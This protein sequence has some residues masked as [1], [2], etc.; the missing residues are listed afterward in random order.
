VAR[1]ADGITTLE[2]LDGGT[3]VQSGTIYGEE[4]G[5][6]LSAPAA[7][8]AAGFDGVDPTRE[9]YEQD[10]AM[11]YDRRQS[12]PQLVPSD[13]RPTSPKRRSGAAGVRHDK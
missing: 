1:A 2:H 5:R 13:R 11:V 4:P 6:R 7:L 9:A 3:P 12:A 10:S 8:H